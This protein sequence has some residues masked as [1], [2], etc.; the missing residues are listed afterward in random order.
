[1]V[2]IAI[3]GVLISI[4]SASLSSSQQRG[5]D[6]KRISDI[7]SIQLA[8][9]TYYNDNQ[10]Y[11]QDIYAAG[12]NTYMSNV[13][14]DPLS[15]ANYKYAGMNTAGAA[16]LCN[17]YHLGAVLENA[18][19]MGQA[20]PAGAQGTACTGGGTAFNGNTKACSAGSATSPRLCYDVTP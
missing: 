18:A 2:V 10:A 1:L 12:F 7:R 13:P 17:T 11:P 16:A 9:E 14:K 6:G 3:I 8:L 4:I 15:G 20:N 19:D 5:R